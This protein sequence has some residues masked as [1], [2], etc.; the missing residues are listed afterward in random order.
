[1]AMQLDPLFRR[2]IHPFFPEIRDLFDPCHISDRELAVKPVDR[3]HSGQ[4]KKRPCLNR[5]GE[6]LYLFIFHKHFYRNRIGKICNI[7]TDQC[8]S[9]PKLPQ[10]AGEH[11]SPD[12]HAADLS[13]DLLDLHRLGVK[14]TAI[15]DIRIVGFLWSKTVIGKKGIAFRL[16]ILFLCTAGCVR[17]LFRGSSRFLF[18]GCLCAVGLSCLLACFHRRI[19]LRDRRDLLLELQLRIFP[20][21]ALGRLDPLCAHMKIQPAALTENFLQ[22]L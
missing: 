18:L 16:C 12:R 8:L 22:N 3:R 13:G 20:P 10:V 15:D 2:C 5:T 17:L 21:L 4:F 7:K 9:D 11:L 14:V 19:M 6:L 1:M